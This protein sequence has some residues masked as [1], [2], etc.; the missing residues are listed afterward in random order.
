MAWAT[1]I[2]RHDLAPLHFA[3]TEYTIPLALTQEGFTF[4]GA[5]LKVRNEMLSGRVE[6]IYHG[7]KRIWRVTLEPIEEGESALI[8]E[9]LGST[10][11]GQQFSFD[12]YGT[13]DA[14]Q[15]EMTVVRE[16]DGATEDPWMRAGD[17]AGADLVQFSFDI[18]QV[19]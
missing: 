17:P 12:P 3:A 19:E 4:R 15:R 7:R 18:R 9:F 2:A 14:P 13:I 10:A 5:D 16:D 11:D 8:R 6:T 1:Y